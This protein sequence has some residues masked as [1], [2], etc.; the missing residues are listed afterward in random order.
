MALSQVG[1]YIEE[2]KEVEPIVNLV[3][4]L[5]NDV[6]PMIRYAVCHAVG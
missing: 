4:T 5:L 1:E 3:M 2:V 6:N